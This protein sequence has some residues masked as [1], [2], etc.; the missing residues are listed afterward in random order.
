MG[1]DGNGKFWTWT[2]YGRIGDRGRKEQL[3]SGSLSDARWYF[4]LKF[5]EKTGLKWEER[6]NDPKPKKY[7]FLERTYEA[8]SDDDGTVKSEDKPTPE[9]TLAPEVQS[10]MKFVF[11]QDYITGTMA[12]IKYDVIK[13]PLGKLSKSTILRGYQAL[14]DLGALFDDHGLA[15]LFHNTDYQ[16]A[17][18]SLS[19]RYYSYIPHAFGRNRPPLIET[20][21]LLKREIQLLEN[22]TDLKDSDDIMRPERRKK[23]NMLDA[24]YKGLGLRELTPVDQS[25]AEFSNIH[26]YLTKTRGSTHGFNYKL[27]QVY[28]LERE[29]EGTR[30]KK[31]DKDKSDRRLLW[32]GSRSTNF[33]GILSQGLRIAPSEAPGKV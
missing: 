28:R 14:K 13:L 24:R 20:L 32:H 19:N 5:K 26:E 16:G 11:N 6:L 18:E 12:D 8:E 10:L 17:V 3:G 23:I 25:S 29:G 21:D 4:E 27:L 2:R 22:L 7:V 33:G 15:E 9:S 30:F 1:F 31:L